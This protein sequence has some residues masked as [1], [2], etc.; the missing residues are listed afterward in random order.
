VSEGDD[1][2]LIRKAI[3]RQ[4][5]LW[6]Y[7]EVQHSA[8]CLG[9]QFDD[10]VEALLHSLEDARQEFI[11]VLKS[12]SK[13]E[14]ELAAG[15]NGATLD[16]ER[17]DQLAQAKK[18]ALSKLCQYDREMLIAIGAYPD[19]L[20]DYDYWGMRDRIGVEEFVWLS[21]GL[22]P[23]ENLKKY[24]EQSSSRLGNKNARLRKE[25]QRRRDLLTAANNLR[26]QRNSIRTDV[27][28]EWLDQVQ[29]AVPEAFRG[30]LL[31]AW[32]RLNTKDA[33]PVV[34]TPNEDDKKPEPR[35][36]RSIAK[37]LT[38][39]AIEEYGY[40]PRAAR[41]PIPGEIE[42]ISDKH[43]LSVSKETVLKYLRIGAKLIEGE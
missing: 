11:C 15:L 43:G 41:S 38:A 6:A 24:F 40:D 32:E 33:V 19:M 27:A 1:D 10:D 25:A 29:L 42:G 20:P 31:K 21:I 8:L 28:K 36:L 39:I 22:E 9:K 14:I 35:E 18:I 30:A 34:T 7:P 3:Q 37:I 26:D 2:P 16:V 17:E 23:D 13:S 5:V 12:F 4:F